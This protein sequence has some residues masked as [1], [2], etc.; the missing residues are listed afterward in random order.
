[1]RVKGE[2]FARR[3][4]YNGKVS[5]SVSPTEIATRFSGQRFCML[6]PH[7]TRDAMRCFSDS[8]GLGA[9]LGGSSSLVSQLHEKL[10]SAIYGDCARPRRGWRLF[11]PE[12]HLLE[13]RWREDADELHFAH[14]PRI[15]AGMHAVV[16]RFSSR[17]IWREYCRPMLC[18][19]HRAWQFGRSGKRA[20]AS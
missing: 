9:G 20:G 3:Y 8:V 6:C 7:A 16:L 19:H 10:S 17:E 14:W 4:D 11:Y 1:M 18:R 2:R 15:H 5:T 13:S 12:L